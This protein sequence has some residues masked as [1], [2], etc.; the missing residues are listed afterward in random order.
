[1]ILL[2]TTLYLIILIFLT[3]KQK[4]NKIKIIFFIG[5]LFSLILCLLGLRI[6][7]PFAGADAMAFENLAW[8]WSQGTLSEIL[9]TF[10][11]S[12]S[13][14][15]S[16]I[17]AFIYFFTGREPI[18]PIIINGILGLFI[19]YY[20]IKLF[21]E[22]WSKDIKNK[23][24][25]LFFILIAFSP[26]LSINSAIILRENY[27]IMFLLIATYHLAR[28]ANNN[29]PISALLF[30]I[31]TLF[32]SFFHSGTILYALG[33]P[34]YLFF[35]KGRN[36][37][38]TKIILGI[39]FFIILAFVLNNLNFGKLKEFQ[40]SGLSIDFISE[41]LESIKEANTTYLQGLVPNNA[42]D[43]LWQ[44]PI[45]LF[46]FL[47]K[48]FIWDIRSFGHIIAFLDS[49]IWI[50]IIYT[51]YKNRY[52]IFNNPAAIA[53]LICCII[54]IFA[55]SYGTS[56][57]GT[58]IRHRTKFYVEMLTLAAPFFIGFKLKGNKN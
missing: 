35:T 19:M 13:Y 56:N 23:N 54:A 17:T 22:T 39:L 5:G 21:D 38:S 34:V 10:D 57:F 29:K 41:K 1:M 28:F 2:C 52:K 15:L 14:V 24:K 20:S 11:I 49:L 12:K 43:I 6:K 18:I 16:S 48:P 36:K 25:I 9:L 44:S 45:R 58:A 27:I 37:Y 26:M 47:T 32:S 4:T 51:I 53:I 3:I 46:F 55:F 31:F 42:F 8:K 30:I 50:F 33:L 7:L 40:D